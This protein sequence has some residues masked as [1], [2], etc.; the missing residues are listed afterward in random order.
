M[1]NSFPHKLASLFLIPTLFFSFIWSTYAQD[2][3]T[4]NSKQVSAWLPGWDGESPFESFEQN[5]ETIDVISP[6]WYGLN[7]DG[8]LFLKQGAEDQSVI[9]FAQENEVTLIPTI[10]NSFNGQLVS[11]VIN[12]P[13]IKEIHIQHIVDKVEEW[14]YDG[15]DIDYEGLFGQPEEIDAFSAFICEL[16]TALKEHDKLLTI[17]VMSKWEAIAQSDTRGQDWAAL[18]QCVDEFRIMTYDYGWRG[19][20]PRPVAPHYWVEEVIEYGIKHVDPAKIRL[21]VPFYGYAWSDNGV[22]GEAEFYS[23]TYAGILDI[24]EVYGVDFQYSPWEKTNKL[25]YVSQYDDRELVHPYEIWF[26]NAVSLEPKLELVEQYDLGGIAIW[27]LG[28]E[29]EENWRLIREALKNQPKTQRQYFEDV[30]P[31][32]QYFNS[33]NRLAFLGLVKGQG[34]TGLFDPLS[35]VNR[36]EILKMSLNSFAVDNSN[37]TF[38]ETRPDDFMNPFPDVMDESWYAAYV[39]TAVDEGVAKGYPDGY[40]RPGNNIIRVEAL[41]LALESAEV[42]LTNFDQSEWLFPYRDWAFD[43]GVYLPE[44]FDPAEEITRAEAAY[45]ID[46]VIEFV[47]NFNL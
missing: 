12:D 39:Q 21:G 37:Y 32:T 24:L 47:E 29:D 25:F 42:D 2:S 33:I 34:E 38:P 5:V 3:E 40:F 10:A 17:A 20:S 14:D 11:D 23:Y 7:E 15:I 46:R 45:I 9:D 28:R 13:E 19:S 1:I 4:E 16:N 41:K 43:Q 22:E 6:F 27:R 18:G 36:A 44:D 26:E 35:K 8:T 30:T 31:D